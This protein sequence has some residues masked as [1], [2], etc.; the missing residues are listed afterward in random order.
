MVDTKWG[1]LGE[2]EIVI[3]KRTEDDGV[4]NGIGVSGGERK[5]FNADG[6]SYLCSSQLLAYSQP[7]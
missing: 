2:L 3:C 6:F 1:H 7:I 4:D 5:L